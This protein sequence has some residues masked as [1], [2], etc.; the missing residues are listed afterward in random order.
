MDFSSVNW[1][2][3]VVGTL[4]AMVLGAIWFSQ[5]TFYPVWWK[6]IGKSDKDA[7]SM[8]NPALMWGLV[9]VAAF[10]VS[11]FMNLMVH[12]LGSLM[13]GGSTLAT[14]ATAGF[15]LWLGFV[16]PASLTNK[17]FANQLLAWVLEA[18]YHLVNFVILGA[19]FGA[20][21]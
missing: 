5:R 7:P 9:V 12:A 15:V 16:A 19:L 3:V 17:L 4:I 11:L 20:W 1:L 21:H 13:P 14:G 8:T 2:A 18:G 10:V 6:A